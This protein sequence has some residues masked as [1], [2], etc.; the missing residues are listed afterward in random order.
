MEEQAP[1]W[2]LKGAGPTWKKWGFEGWGPEG[3]EAQNFAFFSLSP[4]PFCSFCVYLG[5]CSWNFGDV[6]F[7]GA[8]QCAL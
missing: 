7:A 3:W 6:C 1:F 4:P 2:A 8:F 5:V